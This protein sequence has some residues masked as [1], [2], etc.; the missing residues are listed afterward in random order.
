M[1][2]V[3]ASAP[4]EPARAPGAP[5][6]LPA[7]AT[8]A[9]T[10]AGARAAAAVGAPGGP[11]GGAPASAGGATV[12]LPRRRWRHGRRRCRAAAFPRLRSCARAPPVNGGGAAKPPVGPAPATAAAAGAAA[13]PP[14]RAARRWADVASRRPCRR[15]PPLAPPAPAARAARPAAARAGRSPAIIALGGRDRRSSP[16]SRPVRFVRRQR[17]DARAAAEHGRPARVGLD[18]ATG[19]TA[20]ARRRGAGQGQPRRRS[21][22]RYSTAPPS[23]ASR[24]ARPTSSRRPGFKQGVVTNDTTNQT[25]S[26]TAVF[27]ADNQKNAALEVA[28]IVGIPR[29]AVQKL[30]ANTRGVAGRRE[31]V[32]CVGAD[33]AQ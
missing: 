12:V 10:A 19:G 13:A 33:K 17:R 27:Y 18:A 7:A 14:A 32:V 31:V 21:P 15:A 22:S 6:S 8:A 25:R 29:D 24:G 4:G 3:P 11:G 9:A 30:D 1:P 23:P 2:G 28:K 16:W 26:A 20:A 5:M